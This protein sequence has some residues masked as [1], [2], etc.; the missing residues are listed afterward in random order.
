[1]EDSGRTSN[2]Y[3]KVTA[4]RDAQLAQLGID[5]NDSKAVP[6][7]AFVKFQREQIGA[8][9]PTWWQQYMSQD[10]AYYAKN[11]EDLGKILKDPN[12]VQDNAQ[13][14][15]WLASAGDYLTLR[16]YV[17]DKLAERKKNGLSGSITAN[18]NAD[19]A[20]YWTFERKQL[21]SNDQSWGDVQTRYFEHDDLVEVPGG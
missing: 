9:N 14:L 6:V 18:D 20:A 17:A 16:S 11:A 13:G 5:I 21:A 2:D 4:W 10:N 12:F 1:L 15:T 19:L 7:N 3:H 8:A